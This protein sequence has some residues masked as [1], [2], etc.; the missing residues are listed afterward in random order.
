MGTISAS[1]MPL[2]PPKAMTLPESGSVSPARKPNEWY[3]LE[4][5]EGDAGDRQAEVA[6]REVQH[7][8]SSAS[9]ER[10][11]SPWSC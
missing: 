8:D 6:V 5:L 11:C 4:S 1:C 9:Q 3:P 2:S 7:G 10:W